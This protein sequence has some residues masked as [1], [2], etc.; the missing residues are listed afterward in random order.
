MKVRAS[1]FAYGPLAG[2]LARR[3][4]CPADFGAFIT[5]ETKRDLLTRVLARFG[6]EGVVETGREVAAESAHPFVRVL[7]AQ[8]TPS[9][10]LT[11]W[12]QIEVLAH[13]HNRVRVLDLQD[14]SLQLLR[15]R[16]GARDERPLIEEDL[17]ILGVLE[18][19][20][21]LLGLGRFTL[22]GP[23][24]EERGHVWHLGFEQVAPPL[25]AQAQPT[26]R[27]WCA[28]GEI[29][30]SVFVVAV[31]LILAEKPINLALVARYLGLSSRSLQRRLA[32]AGTSFSNLLRAARVTMA[33]ANVV[34]EQQTPL[35]DVAYRFGFS[36]G[37]HMCRAFKEVVGCS[38]S[39]LARIARTPAGA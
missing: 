34:E 29:E 9:L 37:A 10:M 1:R 6:R 30:R 21:A 7:R 20:L 26:D 25:A 22:S 11:A 17:L 38:P 16:L 18:G 39:Q 2:V 24:V 5:E 4:G 32:T 23:V 35:T 31:N 3:I 36:D 33:G 27:I 12:M 8:S 15:F 19:F 13:A 28:E 14:C